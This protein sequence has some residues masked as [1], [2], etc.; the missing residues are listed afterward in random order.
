MPAL[1]GLARNEE[2]IAILYAHGFVDPNLAFVRPYFLANHGIV[3]G[4]ADESRDRSTC[5]IIGHAVA[6]LELPSVY[7]DVELLVLTSASLISHIN[8]L[9]HYSGLRYC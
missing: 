6:T 8:L 9:A 3:C 1:H 4:D 5:H 7:E 2:S